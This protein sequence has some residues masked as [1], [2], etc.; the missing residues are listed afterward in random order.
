MNNENVFFNPGDA[1]AS[2]H[3]FKEARRSAQII[4]ADKPTA[5][6]IVIAQNA[7]SG[8][9]AIYFADKARDDKHG[10]PY[11]ITEKL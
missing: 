4:K 1:I 7:K 6:Q 11:K 5:G 9:Y 2:S 10:E 8:K 3:D